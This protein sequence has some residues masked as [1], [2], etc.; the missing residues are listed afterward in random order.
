MTLAEARQI[1]WKR[2]A[3]TAREDGLNVDWSEEGNYS[4]F[5]VR[6]LERASKQVADTILR[7]HVK[8]V[9]AQGSP[10]SG[11]SPK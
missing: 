11:G 2:L 7:R 5:D 3:V 10:K 8:Q 6:R 1:I 4:A 9:T